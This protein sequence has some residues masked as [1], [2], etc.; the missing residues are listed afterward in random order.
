MYLRIHQWMLLAA[1]SYPD[2]TWMAGW[3]AIKD[4]HQ[5]QTCI[6]TNVAHFFSLTCPLKSSIWLK[7]LYCCGLCK[8]LFVL[9]VG[10][11]A[12]MR[13]ICKGK[14]CGQRLGNIIHMKN[15]KSGKWQAECF[16]LSESGGSTGVFS[17]QRQELQS[18]LQFPIDKYPFSKMSGL[19]EYCVHAKNRR[20]LVVIYD[21]VDSHSRPS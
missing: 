18:P 20:L 6:A 12:C 21:C 4:T 2:H 14:G 16:L 8:L 9:N 13:M 5:T 10:I 3:V 7:V 1:W 17:L 11:V 19:K 15:G